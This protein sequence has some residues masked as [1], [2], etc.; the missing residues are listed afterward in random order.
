MHKML[1]VIRLSTEMNFHVAVWQG[2]YGVV[3][4]AYNEDDDKHY[5]SQIMLLSLL[6]TS[7]TAVLFLPQP[8]LSFASSTVLCF[9]TQQLY[10]ISAGLLIFFFFFSLHLAAQLWL[11][12]SPTSSVALRQEWKKKKG[13]LLLLF[14][15][16]PR[17]N[18]CQNSFAA[19]RSANEE[20]RLTWRQFDFF[21]IQK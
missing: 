14:K 20:Y 15:V 16:Q 18:V 13:R 5:V 19:L 2:S 6:I 12:S 7:G 10:R 1:L 9:H 4:L 8:L 3:K 17:P 21:K 11:W